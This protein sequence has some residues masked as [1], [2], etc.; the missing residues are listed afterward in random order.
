MSSEILT[1]VADP[2][3]HEL[4]SPSKLAYRLN[5]LTALKYEIIP[6]SDS[7]I[8]LLKYAGHAKNPVNSV[9]LLGNGELCTSD[10]WPYELDRIFIASGDDAKFERFMA[11]VENSRKGWRGRLHRYWSMAVEILP[12]L[13]AAT[14]ILHLMDLVGSLINLIRGA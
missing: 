7:N 11:G 8:I 5:R 3:P 6:L 14:I 2:N 12:Y 10:G 9:M 1:L 4:V 13:I